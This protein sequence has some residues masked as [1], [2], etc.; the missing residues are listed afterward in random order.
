[1]DVTNSTSYRKHQV[2]NSHVSKEFTMWLI[3]SFQSSS[4]RVYPKINHNLNDNFLHSNENFI[5]INCRYIMEIVIIG[6]F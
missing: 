4:F 6:F 1:M 5:F 3:V 2:V